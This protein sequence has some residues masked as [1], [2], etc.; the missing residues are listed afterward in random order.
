[1][2]ADGNLDGYAV[3]KLI[4]KAVDELLAQR[5]PVGAKLH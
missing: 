4:I 1:M 5:L 2:M 3:W